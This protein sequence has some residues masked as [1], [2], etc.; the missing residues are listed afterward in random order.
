MNVLKVE[1]KGFENEFF[2]F[3]MKKSEFLKDV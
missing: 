3:C 1:V 2:E